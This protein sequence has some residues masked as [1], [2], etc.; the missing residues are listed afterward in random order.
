MNKNVRARAH[1]YAC[2]RVRVRDKK[3]FYEHKFSLFYSP[4]CYR[5]NA[6]MLTREI[7]RA[8]N[9]SIRMYKRTHFEFQEETTVSANNKLT[10]R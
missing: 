2:T 4:D 10:F 8:L 5:C 6:L 3:K 1:V 9:S 7:R